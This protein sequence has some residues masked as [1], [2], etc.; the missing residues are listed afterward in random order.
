MPQHSDITQA[1]SI[2]YHPVNFADYL[3]Q[4]LGVL[5]YNND[6]DQ[7]FQQAKNAISIVEEVRE[8]IKQGVIDLKD[9]DVELSEVSYQKLLKVW[10]GRCYLL[11]DRSN[12][13]QRKFAYDIPEDYQKYDE[14]VP[15]PAMQNLIPVGNIE[16]Q[17]WGI[18]IRESVPLKYAFENIDWAT[19]VS[20]GKFTFLTSEGAIKKISREDVE[21]ISKKTYFVS[22]SYFNNVVDIEKKFFYLNWNPLKINIH[23][24]ISHMKLFRK[25]DYSKSRKS[26][27]G[28]D[29]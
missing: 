9:S 24:I 1:K 11:I 15:L 16:Q 21:S 29:E 27:G 25:V 4:T 3:Q 8:A 7:F 22:R 14:I 5:N 28:D 13:I 6:Y 12:G 2:V 20:D 17:V 19:V 18:Q 23:R 26:I 10:K